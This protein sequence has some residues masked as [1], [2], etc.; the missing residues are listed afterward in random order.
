MT[1]KL[2]ELCGREPGR[3]FSPYCWRSRMALAHKGLAVETV[4]WRFT[5]TGR[6]AFAGSKTVPVLVDGDT[7]VADSAAIAEHLDAAYP[8]R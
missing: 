1:R 2:F 6:L 3:L 4:P 5:E 8:D 7:A